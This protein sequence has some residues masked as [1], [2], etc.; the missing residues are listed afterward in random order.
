MSVLE[1]KNLHASVDG[2]K[3]LNGLTLTIRAGERHAL[4]GPNGSGKSTLSH[5]IMGH[6]KYEVT[7]GDIRLNGKSVLEWP[8]DVR[9][10][11]GIFLA[12]QY[13]EEVPGVLLPSFL[14]NT[15]TAVHPNEKLLSVKEFMDRLRKQMK[16]IQMDESFIDRYLNEGFSGGEK[17]RNEILQMALIQPQIAILDET[18]SGLDVDALKTVAENVKRIAHEDIGLLIITHYPRILKYIRP[19]FVHLMVKGKIIKSGGLDLATELEEKG[20]AKTLRA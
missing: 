1:I 4:M 19:A 12:F 18:D 8:P 15:Y 7:K 14:R 17:K 2:K 3:I 13:P 9:A 16:L 11:N 10:R 5:L 20:Y 6:P